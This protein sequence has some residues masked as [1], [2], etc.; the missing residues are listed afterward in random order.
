M[1]QVEA[2]DASLTV[3]AI[4]SIG[5]PLIGLNLLIKAHVMVCFASRNRPM[6]YIS[7]GGVA[8]LQINVRLQRDEVAV[9]TF[10]KTYY[11]RVLLQ[12]Q[13]RQPSLY[14]GLHQ[15]H[16]PSVTPNQPYRPTDTSCLPT[17]ALV[18]GTCQHS[19]T[20]SNQDSSHVIGF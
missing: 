3:F 13:G 12:G 11:Q 16:R 17:L 20:K 19:A 2:A 6:I 1:V 5:R 9:L 15:R 4:S 7:T 14:I 10:R 18:S 8:D